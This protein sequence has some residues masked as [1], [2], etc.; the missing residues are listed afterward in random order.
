MCSKSKPPEIPLPKGWGADV[1][2]ATIHIIALAQYALTYSRSWAADNSHQ[3]IRLKAECDPLQQEVTLLRE[4]TNQGRPDSAD[5]SQAETSL[6]THRTHGDPEIACHPR[7]VPGAG[8]QGIPGDGGDDQFLG[9][10]D[11]RGWNRY[12]GGTDVS[13]GQQVSRVGPLSCRAAEG[14]LLV[15]HQFFNQ[16]GSAQWE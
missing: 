15:E 3:R 2:S 10:A 11:R 14:S 8:G 1:K 9:L 5:R 7:L 4:E 12:P 13:A 6:S 16:P